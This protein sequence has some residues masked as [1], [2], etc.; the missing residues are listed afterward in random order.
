VPFLVLLG[1]LLGACAGE[2][3]RYCTE[4]EERQQVLSE[5]AGE[6][7]RPDSDV[8]ASTLETWRALREE[9]PGDVRDE[10]TTL[11]FALE[12]LAEAL[13]EAGVD[14][15]AFDPRDPPPG[16]SDEEAE[17]LRDA[18]AELVTPRVTQAAEGLE[19][20]ALDV[21]GVDL[22]LSGAA[23]DETRSGTG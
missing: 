7:G 23:G 1:G 20:H 10:W 16:M 14:A 15:G 4:L 8:L 13:A 17:R 6:A 9:A 2:T 21:C 18:A 12:G 11:V 5:L 19:Q 3:E 22:G